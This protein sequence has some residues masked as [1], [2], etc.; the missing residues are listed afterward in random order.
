MVI[1]YSG[2]I[3]D[4]LEEQEEEELSSIPVPNVESKTLKNLIRLLEQSF[5]ILS[6]PMVRDKKTAIENLISKGTFILPPGREVLSLFA[7]DKDGDLRYLTRKYTEEEYVELIKAMH[8]L[9]VHDIIYASLICSYAK[10]MQQ[11]G[12]TFGPVAA[13]R[14]NELPDDIQWDIVSKYFKEKHQIFELGYDTFVKYFHR[15]LSKDVRFY[16]EPFN[17]IKAKCMKISKIKPERKMIEQFR[18]LREGFIKNIYRFEYYY[19]FGGLFGKKI[20]DIDVTLVGMKGLK[21]CLKKSHSLPEQADLR[22]HGT[23]LEL[24]IVNLVKQKKFLN[25]LG[26]KEIDLNDFVNA[27]LF[28]I[29]CKIEQ[30]GGEKLKVSITN[31]GLTEVPNALIC[32]LHIPWA[33]RDKIFTLN[34]SDNPITEIPQWF[35]DSFG[36]MSALGPK[37]FQ[38]YFQNTNLN[39]KSEVLLKNLPKKHSLDARGKNVDWDIQSSKKQV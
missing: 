1:L 29:F 18:E 15:F 16:W 13:K 2:L 5:I 25:V 30:I 34:L 38:I 24:S 28:F 20:D 12:K 33:H 7:K 8:Y 6:D 19:K 23:N 35:V 32:L 9:Y 4:M 37:K 14:F 26:G 31:C 22:T 27:A 17:L 3:K 11:I 21:G 10:M 36:R 39:E